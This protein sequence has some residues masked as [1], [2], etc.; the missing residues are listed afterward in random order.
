MNNWK[1]AN[2]IIILRKDGQH[3]SN[4]QENTEVSLVVFPLTPKRVVPSQLPLPKMNMIGKAIEISDP[5]TIDTIK[6]KFGMIN[7]NSPLLVILLS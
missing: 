7:F 4:V 1:P 3:Y 6:E 2:P 5:I